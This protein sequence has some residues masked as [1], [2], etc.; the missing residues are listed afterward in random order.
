MRA[1]VIVAGGTGERFGGERGK[2]L[3]TV[4]GRP[5]L[6]WT[7]EAFEECASVDFIVLVCH[8]D[9]VE[10]YRAAAIGG[11]KDTKVGAVVPGGSTRRRS[12]AAGLAVLP[13][14][15]DVVAV[16]DGARAFI[17]APTIAA[18]FTAL[19]DSGAGGVVV[20]H[21]AVD[22]VKEVDGS[23]RVVVTPDRSRSWIAQTPQAFRVDVL[24]RAHA[25]AA[26]DGFEGT[27]DAS[28]VERDGGTVLM[29]EG[30]RWNLKVTMAE[31]LDV[32]EALLAHRARIGAIDA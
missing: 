20:G 16:H 6:A 12:V 10:E 9:R 14:G 1:A 4:A 32:M 21:P 28:L 8:P 2:Q 25:R 26:A 17:D 18:A 15:C 29:L 31:D 23:H 27:D 24:V 3:A 13:G 22:T 19:D 11:R 30:P 5:L 7:V